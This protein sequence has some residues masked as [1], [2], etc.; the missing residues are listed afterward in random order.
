MQHFPIQENGGTRVETTYSYYTAWS[1]ERIDSSRFDDPQG[2]ENPG[3]SRYS[4]VSSNRR[5][6]FVALVDNKVR[7]NRGTEF[8]LCL[9]HAASL[10]VRIPT[11]RP[12]LSRRVSVWLGMLCPTRCGLLLEDGRASR[13]PSQWKGSS[14][15]VGCVALGTFQLVQLVLCMDCHMS[16]RPLRRHT[17]AGSPTPLGSE[18]SALVSNSRARRGRRCVGSR[19]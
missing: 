14:S 16:F 7:T 9:L 18:M 8:L 10:T 1:G 11:D 6:A 2:H 19:G 12:R 3:S 13:P 4:Y 5:S 17:T 15:W